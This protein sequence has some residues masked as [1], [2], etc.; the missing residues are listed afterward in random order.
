MDGKMIEPTQRRDAVA[1]ILEI[2]T[3]LGVFIVCFIFLY[4][5]VEKQGERIEKQGERIDKV[6]E[7]IYEIIREKRND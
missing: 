5:L 2:S 6:Y 3:I 7:M 4:N 1:V